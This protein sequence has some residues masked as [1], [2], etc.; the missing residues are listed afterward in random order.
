M[1]GQLCMPL[2]GLWNGS[3]PRP[4]LPSWL[5]GSCSL[6]VGTPREGGQPSK[7]LEA[8]VSMLTV[9]NPSF[10]AGDLQSFFLHGPE[11]APPPTS[12]LSPVSRLH[13]Q[14]AHCALSWPCFPSGLYGTKGAQPST[15]TLPIVRG[16]RR[17]SV[18]FQL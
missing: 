13:F 3:L 11:G 4:C 18:V 15:E 10:C 12:A 14:P 7:H 9:R 1:R 8:S 17:G 6:S 2:R 5:G 16:G